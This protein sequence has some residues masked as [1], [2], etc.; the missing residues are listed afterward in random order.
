[1]L[2]IYSVLGIVLDVGDTSMNTT[3]QN[4]C[5]HAACVLQGG[6]YSEQDKTQ[7]VMISAHGLGEE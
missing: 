3:D 2:I 6:T 4:V 7:R 1:M 5:S